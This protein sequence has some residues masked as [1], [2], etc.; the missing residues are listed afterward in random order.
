MFIVV[1]FNTS[2]EDAIV[3]MIIEIIPGNIAFLRCCQST[4]SG[5]SKL[6]GAIFVP[7]SKQRNM[8]GPLTQ[9]SARGI[10]LAAVRSP[11]YC[12]LRSRPFFLVLFPSCFLRLPSSASLFLPRSLPPALFVRTLIARLDS[13]VT[14]ILSSY[15]FHRSVS[16]YSSFLFGLCRSENSKS[17]SNCSKLQRARLQAH[18]T[19]PYE[20]KMETPQMMAKRKSAMLTRY[21]EKKILLDA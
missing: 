3:G 8:R 13:A 20:P 19:D 2:Y 15:A 9:L 12:R 14:A 16:I 11:F 17:D 7:I 18:P 5:I 1:L 6:V 21:S 4:A 10:S